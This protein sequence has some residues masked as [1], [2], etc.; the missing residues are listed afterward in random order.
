VKV[1]IENSL[2]DTGEAFEVLDRIIDFFWDGRHTWQVDPALDI[3]KTLWI[4]DEP[5][6]RAS[7]KNL[8]TYE[9]HITH[10]IYATKQN[11][12]HHTTL[13][14]KSKPKNPEDYTVTQA[15]VYLGEPVYIAV[16]N[17]ENDGKALTAIIQAFGRKELLEAFQNRWIVFLHLGGCG[18]A[19]KRVRQVYER[20]QQTLGRKPTPYRL[21]IILDSDR[22]TLDQDPKNLEK[23]NTIKIKYQVGYVFLQKRELENYIPLSVLGGISDK[24]QQF[25]A[26]QKLPPGASRDFYDMKYGFKKK[27]GQTKLY[28]LQK[29]LYRDISQDILDALVS[30]FGKN[31]LQNLMQESNELT[32]QDFK[33][34]CS[35]GHQE[36]SD[37]LDNMEKLF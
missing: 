24:E 26:F 22:L 19:N 8:E 12:C 5:N 28:P 7:R 27:K 37:I 20:I 3:K 13:Y 21:I 34:T 29:E 6:S 18:E 31:V 14:I 36:L 30:G 25:Q 15:L 2:F 11:R 23:I 4:Q 16:E 9:K 10:Q 17:E 35:S 33:D 32:E 1:T